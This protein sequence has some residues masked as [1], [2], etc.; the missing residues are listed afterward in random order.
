MFYQG[1]NE[2]KG[3]RFIEDRGSLRLLMWINCTRNIR[4]C[5]LTLQ[6]FACIMSG[7]D[8]ETLRDFLLM[9]RQALLMIVRWIEKRYALQ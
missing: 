8:E 2:R 4:P 6:V 9:V 1:A 3:P 7:M 5:G